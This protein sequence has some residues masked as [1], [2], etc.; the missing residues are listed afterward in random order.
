MVVLA[1]RSA[2]LDDHS[3]SGLAQH[4]LGYLLSQL[5]SITFLAETRPAEV[6]FQM[7]LLSEQQRDGSS[8][9]PVVK[10]SSQN[11]LRWNLHAIHLNPSCLRYWKMLFN[12]SSYHTWSGLQILFESVF[13]FYFLSLGLFLGNKTKIECCTVFCYFLEELIMLIFAVEF[14]LL[15]SIWLWLCVPFFSLDIIH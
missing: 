14:E 12:S 3:K 10:K 2:F 5:N 1:T 11:P 8:S 13:F 7:H 15:Y 4:I 9:L 6:Y